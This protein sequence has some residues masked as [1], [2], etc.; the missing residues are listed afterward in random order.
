[1]DTP[2][3]PGDQDTSPDTGPA[4]DTGT[5]EEQIDFEK[6]YN[7]LRSEFDSR[8]QQWSE[9]QE[10]LA[11][12]DELVRQLGY[13][14]GD[15]EDD[16]DYDDDLDPVGALQAQVEAL[17][18]ER[19]QDMTEAQA[20]SQEQA[21]LA[22]INDELQG[23]VDQAGRNF[24]QE[25][26]DTIG[27]LSRVR[28]TEDGYPDVQGAYKLLYDTVLSSEKQRWVESKNAP[29]VPAGP[30]GS[31]APDL[32]NPQVRQDYMAARLAQIDAEQ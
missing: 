26:I 3:T 7:D 32:D 20:Q 8:N 29:Q 15:E 4:P 16:E 22:Y 24:T 23:V 1:M 6:R 14:I 30:A 9:F 21:E 18:A 11:D 5:R 25:E 13:Q 2:E 10:A 12:P 19:A 27:D 28:L 31:E 17:Q